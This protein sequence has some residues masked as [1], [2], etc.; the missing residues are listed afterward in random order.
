MSFL[1]RDEV[2][3][4][5]GRMHN[6]ELYD[7][8]SSPNIIPMVI[9]RRRWAGHVARVWDM[10]GTYKVLTGKPEGKRSHGKNRRGWGDI[11]TMD[12]QEVRWGDMDRIDMAQDR[13]MWRDVLN[14]V[15]KL[16]IP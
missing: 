7:L 9:L 6:E 16:R 3:G 12:F 13:N 1:K 10:R 15:M 5:R 4:E 2:T 14:A 11:I 8:S